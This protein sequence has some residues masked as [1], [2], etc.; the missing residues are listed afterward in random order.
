MKFGRCKFFKCPKVVTA[1]WASLFIKLPH[2]PIACPNIRY[3]IIVSIVNKMF[4]LFFLQKYTT[5]IIPEI[6]A[7]YMARPP[8]HILNIS[9]RLSLNTEKLN[10][11]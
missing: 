4:L 7:P 10:I 11:T 5:N 6:T 9:N 3:G 8:S 2:L 1:P